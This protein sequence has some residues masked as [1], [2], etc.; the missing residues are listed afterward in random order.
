MLCAN[1][2]TARFLKKHNISALYRVHDKP[3]E[4]KLENLRS[5]LTERNLG[6]SGGNEPQPSDYQELFLQ[7][8]G[9][10]DA[11]L[12]QIM[13][14]RSMSQAKYEPE[15]RGHFG[16]A[17]SEYTHFTSP[18]RR[19]PDLL[20]HRAI[21]SVIRS[22]TESTHVKRVGSQSLLE[23]NRIYPYDMAQLLQ[24]G[25]HCSMAERR[26]D[27]ATRDVVSWLKCEYLQ[28]HLGDSFDGIICGIASFGF[29]V[30]LKNIYVEGMVHVSQ[31][32]SDFFQYDAAKQRLIGERTRKIFHI[33]DSVKVTVSNIDLT[34]RRI[35]L[36]LAGTQPSNKKTRQAKK[37]SEAADKK[38]G[39]NNL[40]NKS[41]KTKKKKR[42]PRRR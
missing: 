5:F 29:F 10:E 32:G 26:A 35:H 20:T 28:D 1:V 2:A 9:R 15:N 37:G 6:L 41:S 33:G 13:M 4:K 30:E 14:L 7:L 38:S 42:S 36:S 12:V 23:L 31:L 18:I 40:N 39:K 27:D 3:S 22:N 19:Y 8:E 16:L 17:Y 21:R 11:Q 25:E 34:E 24:L